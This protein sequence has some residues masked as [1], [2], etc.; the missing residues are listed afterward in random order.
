MKEP[1][2]EL[3]FWE[4]AYR[5]FRDQIEHE[6][7]LYNQ[8]ILWLIYIQAFLFATLGLLMRARYAENSDA[9]T[10]VYMVI[11]LI[12]GLG[13]FIAVISRRV[14]DNSGEALDEIREMW[15]KLVDNEM[16]EKLKIYF[17]HVSGGDG[18]IR[19]IRRDPDPQK[20]EAKTLF[21]SRN[22]PNVLCYAWAL[23]V[24]FLAIDM[25]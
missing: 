8:R 14:L 3:R 9:V 25:L 5:R 23:V 6:D 7:T 24:L 1:I 13:V 10:V 22:L 4:L 21:R 19:T 17:P 18:K 20:N 15:T 11:F 12:G 16:P 2:C